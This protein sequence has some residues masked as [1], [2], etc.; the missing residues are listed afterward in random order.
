MKAVFINGSPR[1]NGNTAAIMSEIERGIKEKGF[2]V[3][4]FLLH[5]MD[6]RFCVGC[7]VCYED[8]ACVHNDDVAMMAQAIFGSDLV[9][10]GSPSYWGDVTAQ[11]KTFIDR[12]TPWCDTNDKRKLFAKG[13]KGAAVAVRAGGNKAENENLVNTIEHF[14]GHLDIPLA[15]SFT[16]ERIDTAADLAAR[17][18][19]LKKAYEFGVTLGGFREK[20]LS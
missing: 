4:S 5:D 7:K 9:V 8:G 16:A 19:V 2:E 14:L 11:L 18:E 10:V 6:I 1:K 17:P 3:K 20:D 12:C 15:G 13:I